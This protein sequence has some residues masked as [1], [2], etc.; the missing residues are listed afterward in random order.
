MGKIVYTIGHSNHEPDVFIA[1]LKRYKI[2][3]LVDV[4]SQPYSSYIKQFSKKT[5]MDI[6]KKNGIG[7]WHLGAMGGKPEDESL[8]RD[9][10]V[11][12]ELIKKSEAYKTSFKSLKTM[13]SLKTV[14]LMCAEEDPAKCHRNQMMTPELMKLGFEVK[15]IRSDGS[16]IEGFIAPESSEPPVGTE[17]KDN[18]N[19]NQI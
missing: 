9:G 5:L 11:D 18:P 2:E 15:H 3:L 14:V 16:I 8:Y 4:R 19:H 13:I 10:K 12:F 1:L 7:Y 6:L 17:I